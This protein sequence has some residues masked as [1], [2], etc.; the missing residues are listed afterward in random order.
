MYISDYFL[1]CDSIRKAHNAYIYG[2]VFFLAMYECPQNHVHQ[3][4]F[5]IYLLL[6]FI[7]IVQRDILISRGQLFLFFVYL[8]LILIAH[9]KSCC[10]VVPKYFKPLDYKVVYF[11]LLFSLQEYFSFDSHD[12]SVSITFFF[13]IL[14]FER[15]H[16]SDK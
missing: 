16:S 1:P 5:A 9:L 10:V 8:L 6:N 7:Q 13:I 3:C 14:F 15:I 4:I 11:R 12:S 2:F